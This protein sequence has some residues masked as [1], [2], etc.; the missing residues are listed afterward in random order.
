MI[1]IRLRKFGTQLAGDVNK[2]GGGVMTLAAIIAAFL[3]LSLF[4]TMLG[5]SPKGDSE[6]QIDPEP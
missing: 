2:E 5:S 6:C 3:I 1:S 4:L